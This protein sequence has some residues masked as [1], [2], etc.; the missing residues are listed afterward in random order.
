MNVMSARKQC[1]RAIEKGGELAEAKGMLAMKYILDLD[2]VRHGT[3][4]KADLAVRE[5]DLGLFSRALD[6]ERWEFAMGV[7]FLLQSE[8]YRCMLLEQGPT[9]SD[10]RHPALTFCGLLDRVQNLAFINGPSA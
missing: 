10:L 3:R 1:T 7:D 9:R 4:N 6:P 2:G 5:K 8:E